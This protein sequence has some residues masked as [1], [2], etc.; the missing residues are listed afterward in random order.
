LAEIL[1]GVDE[2]AANKARARAA[3]LLMA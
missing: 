2:A 1:P 3:E